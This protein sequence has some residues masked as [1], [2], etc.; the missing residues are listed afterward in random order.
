MGFL[1]GLRVR[2]RNRAA[3]RLV[4]ILDKESSH[5]LAGS[6]ERPVSQGKW[7]RWRATQEATSAML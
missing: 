2:E 3:E 1:I 5:P 6:L 7:V 4:Y